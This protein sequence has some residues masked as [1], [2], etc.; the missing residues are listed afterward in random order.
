MEKQYKPVPDCEALR[1][2][3]TP[4]KPDIKIFVSHR[5]DLEA[6]TIDNPLYIPVR[7]GAVYDKRENVTMLG[8]DTGDNISEKRMSFNELTV[9]YWAWKNVK[10]DYYGLCHYRRYLSFYEKELPC[11]GLKQAILP[12]MN[13]ELLKKYGFENEAKI[14]EEIGRV[15]AVFCPDYDMEKDY[16]HNNECKNIKETWLKYSSA[17]LT[18]K[19]FDTLLALIEKQ[20]PEYYNSACEYMNGRR[21]R[22][23]NCFIM[24]RELFNQLCEFAYSVLFEFAKTLDSENT[25]STQNRAPGY[26][27]EWL[28]SIFVYHIQKEKKYKIEERQLIAFTNTEK[29]KALIPLAEN[30]NVTITYTLKTNNAVKIAAS[31]QQIIDHTDSNVHYDI[32]LLRPSLNTDVPLN[33]LRQQD[34]KYLLSMA[35]KND[36]VTIRCYDPAHTLGEL[37]EFPAWNVDGETPFYL[38]L[39]PWILAKY[40]QCI[41][42]DENTLLNADIAQLW[43][44]GVALVKEKY[45]AAAPLSPLHGAI[46]NGFKFEGV[47]NFTQA[48]LENPYQY[49]ST[50]IV[51]L[52]LE[53]IRKTLT[54]KDVTE[55][56]KNSESPLLAEDSFNALL[57]DKIAPLHQKWNKMVFSCPDMAKFQEYIPDKLAKEQNEFMP[58]LAV[59]L[60]EDRKVWPSLYTEWTISYWKYL[61]ETEYYERFMI[62]AVNGTIAPIAGGVYQLQQMH[63][64]APRPQSRARD[65]ADKLMPKG[66]TRRKIAKTLCPK[67]SPQW[68]LLKAI[69]RIFD[70]K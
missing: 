27:S 5:I 39:L 24:K 52:N 54:K 70:R 59:N 14:R 36:N 57:E 50:Q 37:D 68:N 35:K 8:D 33:Q 23:F 46:A 58:P 9:Q 15:D 45:C 20:A 32:I 51:F 47:K 40:Q 49:C 66:S 31:I 19:Q 4:D 28:F 42:L 22:G 17:Y 21:F 56:L 25:S 43:K 26:A 13:E 53:R 30:N 44:E 6:Q 10:A 1:Y 65:L 2:K 61:R 62:E 60:L 67:G 29:E 48:K 12:S 7:C 69:Y 11:E 63:G 64:L 16:I 18:E 3:G 41:Y 55:Y 38:S 34:L